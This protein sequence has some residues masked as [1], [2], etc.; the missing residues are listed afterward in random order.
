[1]KKF[2]F[3]IL[4]FLTLKVSAQNYL[5]DFAGTGASTTVNSVKVENLTKATSLTLNSGELLQ[6]TIT[7][8]INSEEKI[9]TTHIKA[10]PNPATDVCIIQVEPE[11]SGNAV[12]T[13]I[14]ATG[15]LVYQKNIFLDKN[16]NEYQISGLKRGLNLITITGKTYR[17]TSKV[18]SLAERKYPLNLERIEAL[19]VQIYDEKKGKPKGLKAT[20]E[21]EYSAG[22][23]I[24]YTGI[25]GN[26]STVITDI[27]TEN[28]TITFNFTSC[29]DGDNLNYPVVF[30]GTQI[31]MAENLKTTKY[32]DGTLITLVSDGTVWSNLS[33]EA[34]CWYDNNQSSYGN[35]YGALYNYYAVNT[36]KLC[37]SGWHVAKDSD[38][39]TLIFY[40]VANGFNYDGTGDYNKLTKSLGATTNWRSSTFSPGCVGST[41]YPE[42]RNATGFTALPGGQRDGFGTYRDIAGYAAWWT[43]DI[44]PLG[45]NIAYLYSIAFVNWNVL[46]SSGGARS[47]LSVR[48]IKD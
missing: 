48:C 22:D 15:K 2:L 4:I 46:K 29:T 6:L 20:I 21:M 33:T 8:G 47:G 13:L 25:S 34:Y 11:N 27:P 45:T 26:Y 37:P 40:L 3:T 36:G 19:S 16:I 24:K 41:A 1:M 9:K 35:L 28:K 30:I 10:W 31:W 12:F 18:F 43:G 17:Y 38:W 32:N 44:I 14:D 7:T 42:K 39:N 5:I 23:R